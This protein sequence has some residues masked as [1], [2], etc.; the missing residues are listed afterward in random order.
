M[1]CKWG[2]LANI[3]ARQV[4]VSTVKRAFL[5]PSFHRIPRAKLCCSTFSFLTPT[6]IPASLH[7]CFFP[8]ILLPSLRCIPCAKDPGSTGGGQLCEHGG[9]RS[10]CKECGGGSICE[11]QRIRSQCQEC[12]FRQLFHC[13]HRIPRSECDNASC[14]VVG[15]RTYRQQVRAVN[16]EAMHWQ[17]KENLARLER[18]TTAAAAAAT[19]I[20]GSGGG[21]A[22]SVGPASAG[23][24]ARPTPPPAPPPS[25]FWARL[26]EC[27]LYWGALLVEYCCV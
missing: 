6:T 11:H 10:G 12:V 20:V 18:S 21:P 19:E 16:L 9:R 27:K 3:S 25:D 26:E 4:R 15:A 22:T 7:A 8:A 1:D 13:V 23:A 14:A 5:L 2:G 24:P 17:E